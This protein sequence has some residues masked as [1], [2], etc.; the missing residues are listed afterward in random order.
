MNPQTNAS[1]KFNPLTLKTLAANQITENVIRTG[2]Y[3]FK[4]PEIQKMYET[5]LSRADMEC[6]CLHLRFYYCADEDDGEHT[7]NDDYEIGLLFQPDAHLN[8]SVEEQIETLYD[9][10][11]EMALDFELNDNYPE[12]ILKCIR[13]CPKFLA[14]VM[15][16]PDWKCDHSLASWRRILLLRAGIESNPGPASVDFINLA[17]RNIRLQD[18]TISQCAQEKDGKLTWFVQIIL[19]S[20]PSLSSVTFSHYNKKMAYELCYEQI[21]AKINAKMTN[22]CFDLEPEM[23]QAFTKRRINDANHES[24]LPTEGSHGE[25]TSETISVVLSLIHI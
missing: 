8:M 25:T 19:N 24:E 11:Q 23:L 10:I 7:L 9:I 21:M 3:R 22:N 13:V 12:P 1:E 17:S 6:R 4:E 5:I 15:N 14:L 2:L 18:Q 20:Y 16:L